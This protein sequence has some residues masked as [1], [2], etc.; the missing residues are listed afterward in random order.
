MRKINQVYQEKINRNEIVPFPEWPI[1]FP[2]R[3]RPIYFI[4]RKTGEKWRGILGPFGLVEV[5]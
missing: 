5:K 3:P 2:K 1:G 4:D